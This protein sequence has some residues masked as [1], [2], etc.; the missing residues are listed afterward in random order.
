MLH[1]DKSILFIYLFIQFSNPFSFLDLLSCEFEK[2]RGRDRHFDNVLVKDDNHLLHI[3]FGFVMGNNPPIDGPPIA[4]APQME[5]AFRR[6]DVW[7]LFSD[8]F[9]DAFM[10]LRERAPSIVRTSILL[11]SMAG[12]NPDQIRHFLSSRLSLNIHEHDQKSKDF[13]KRQLHMSSGDIKTKFKQFSH[14][15]IDPAW[16]G[17][18][19]KGFPPAVAIM[20][21][22][23]AKDNRVARRL[24]ENRKQSSIV[25]DDERITVKE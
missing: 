7:D 20:K 16:Y 11:F 5:L 23:D 10:A 4:I 22:V 13:M 18:L 19:E 6:L 12:F 9:V 17:L 21:I 15:H 3:D 14:A 25:A 24:A 8:M 2:H 1:L